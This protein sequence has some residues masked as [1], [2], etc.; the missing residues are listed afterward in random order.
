MTPVVDY[1]LPVDAEFFA[2]MDCVATRAG[3]C[4][5][6]A[7]WFKAELADGITFASSPSDPPSVYG[8]GYFPV[9]EPIEVSGGDVLTC[10]L[11]ARFAGREPVWTWSV[12][13][14]LAP[15][16]PARH[17]SLRGKVLSGDDLKPRAADFVPK[18]DVEGEIDRDILALMTGR[19]RNDEIAQ[20][21][22][23]R[24][25]STFRNRQEALARVGTLASRYRSEKR[26]VAG[27]AE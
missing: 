17:S 6:L 21:I 4:H 20:E 26:V 3:V 7:A 1:R 2:T 27:S 8:Q 12:G 5:G 22:E 9:E 19:R 16:P 10:S 15:S 23:A 25:P 14:K 11:R 18:L 13:R 24:F